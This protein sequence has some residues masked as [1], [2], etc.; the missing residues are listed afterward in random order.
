MAPITHISDTARWVAF[1]RAMETERPDAL[2]H[3]P[4][5][6][7]LA[8]EQGEQIVRGL[9]WG[10]GMAWAMI[11]RTA[12]LDELIMRAVTRD[13]CDTVL[14]LAAGLDARAY[15]LDLPARL[16]WVDVDLPGI[17][18]YK[19]EQLAGETPRCRLETVALDLTDL[20]GRRAL[21]ARLGGESRRVVV[22]TE[23]L[24]AYLKPEQVASLATDLHAPLSFATWLAEVASPWILKFM[25]RRYGK[26]LERGGAPMH[27]G[28]EEGPKFFLPYGWACTEERIMLDEGRRLQRTPAGMWLW[29]LMAVT[30][31]RQEMMRKASSIIEL[32]RV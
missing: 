32:S 10:R 14:N 17:L 15:R 13:G 30:R 9:R 20:E 18:A 3:D 24:L 19:A 8:G 22:V 27:F 28:P 16:R 12:V 25:Q 2:F 29:R 7:R 31:R 4:F 26:A 21:F 11:V 6:R 5:A 23:G 1:Y